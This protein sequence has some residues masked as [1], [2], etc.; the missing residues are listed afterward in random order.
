MPAADRELLERPINL[1]RALANNV[2]A[3]RQ[4]QA[5]SDWIRWNGTIDPRQRELAILQVGLSTRS[6]YEVTHHVELARGFG[7]TDADL[8]DLARLA[9][10]QPARQLSAADL[11]VV[12]AA[13]EMAQTGDLAPAGWAALVEAAG[14]PGAVEFVVVIG[15]YGAVTQVLSALQI[16]VEP[17]YESHLAFF[18]EATPAP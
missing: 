17:E 12:N 13:R 1:F 9:A 11:A 15:F 3:L 6:A 2:G 14:Q 4:W 5:F 16:D 18:R 10:G 8:D 7:V